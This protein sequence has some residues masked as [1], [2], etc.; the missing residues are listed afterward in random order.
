MQIL[1]HQDGYVL[2]RYP[3]Y[4]VTLLVDIQAILDTSPVGVAITVD[5]VLKFVNPHF[6]EMMG[7]NKGDK[8]S[9]AYVDTKDRSQI[10]S[11]TKEENIIKNYELQLYDSNHNIRD[12]LVTFYNTDYQ[13]Q[14]AILGWTIDITDRKEIEN[15]LQH[16]NFLNDQALGLTKAGYWHVAM[17]DS[18]FY[19]S[20]K[21]AVDIFGDIPNK[22]YRYHIMDDWLVHVEE[23]DLDAAKLT[24]QNFQDTIEEKVPAF[25]SIYA[26]KRP[27]DG[28][29]VWIHAYGTIAKDSEGNVTDM[30]GV[31]QDIT[32]YIHVQQEMR[33]AKEVAEDATKAKSDFLANMSHEIRTPMNAIIGMSHLALQT[34]LNRKQRNYV[35]KVHRSGESLLGI[36]N[37]ILDFSKIEAGKLDMESTD[38]RLE[39]VFD[40]LANLVGLKAEEEGL[41][42]MF[43]LAADLPTGLIGDPLR[44]GQILINIGNN[45]V[46][47]TTQGEIVFHVK[48]LEQS[49]EEA[50]LQ[51]SVRDS[52]VGM[53]AEQQSKLFQSFSQADTSTTR[54]YGGT[55]LGLAISKKLT[56]MMDG[57][58]WVDSEEG[59]GSTFHFTARFGKQQGEQSKRRSIATDLG[60]MRV[61]VVDDNGTSREILS[62]MLAS[63]GLQVDQA[64]TGETALVQLQQ[65]SDYDPYKLVL[66]DWKMPGMDGIETTRAIQSNAQLIE[67]PTVIMVT[68]YGR[69][70]A[71]HA[72]QGVNISGFLTKPVTP[73]SLLDAIMVAM[74]HEVSNEHQIGNSQEEAQLAIVKLRGAQVLLVE[75]NEI[76]QELALEL[77]SANGVNVEVAND[78]QE[79]LDIL[80]DD[81]FASRC[82]GVLMDCQ[83]PVMDG[84]EAT[85]QL[86]KQEQ[87]KDLPIL[88]MTANA[89]LGDKEKVINAGMNDHIAKPINV[90]NMFNTMAQWIVPSNPNREVLLTDDESHIISEDITELAGIDVSAGL[91]TCQGN[92]KLYRKLLVKFKESMSN[93]KQQF[94]TAQD[95]EDSDASARCVH[96]LK[97]VAGNIGATKVYEAAQEL[98]LACNE[99]QL[100]EQIQPLLEN[101]LSSLSIVLSSLDT[102]E[103][104]S[105]PISKEDIPLDTEKLQLLL[106]QLRELLEDDDA[107]AADI[108][109]EI[110]ELPGITSHQIN[111]KRL[112]K[113][114]DGYDF[115]LALEELDKFNIIPK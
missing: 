16:S 50:K 9:S 87:F 84:Y 104:E 45:A 52:G 114:I 20:S 77:L 70:E 107:D 14:K 95:S 42:L 68:A 49:E 57:K 48:L 69:E 94:Q 111:L 33:L 23:G 25:D 82:D 40:N 115:E 37:D 7:L 78:G 47:F 17:D 97:G 83:M 8:I 64:G 89:M 85:R 58:I 98:E 5:G 29:V 34:E 59:E 11:T 56:E 72:A 96:S 15:K 19:N 109:E 26:Y 18:G 46:K 74:G 21:R 22:D 35:E 101:V 6:V 39:D 71:H 76:N 61:L 73:S 53:S 93:F 36:I 2:S 54:K 38:F 30:Y 106:S 63:F 41:E 10:L 92:Q 110:E 12:M 90:Q 108:V 62:E 113:A 1:H 86:R 55:G 100:D 91:A 51:F 103:Q 105:N 79:A 32:E 31:T 102:L 80:A 4:W 112:L 60:A 65:A 81:D 28:K 24:F 99:G 43:D 44:L 75:D 13:G 3:V 67:I 66:M 88:A 27:I